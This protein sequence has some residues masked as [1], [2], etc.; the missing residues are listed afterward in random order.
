MAE[1]QIKSVTHTVCANA[2]AITREVN[3]ALCPRPQCSEMQEALEN[4]QCFGHRG[5]KA[6]EARLD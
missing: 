6:V 4:Y 5:L 1:Q 3:A 2:I